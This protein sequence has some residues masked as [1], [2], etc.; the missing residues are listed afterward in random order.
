[1]AI[2]NTDEMS[3][4]MGC[5]INFGIC[6]VASSATSSRTHLGYFLKSPR[7][8][9]EVSAVIQVCVHA[10]NLITREYMMFSALFLS[11]IA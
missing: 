9:S 5:N 10:I 7:V 3:I 11:N 4:V 8:N 2:L 1:M 6:C